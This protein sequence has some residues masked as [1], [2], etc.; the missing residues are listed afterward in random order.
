MKKGIKLAQIGGGSSYTPDFAEILIQR[1]D[2]FP[3]SDG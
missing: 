3:V 1:R 2:E